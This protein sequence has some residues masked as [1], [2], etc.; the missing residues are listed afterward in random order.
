MGGLHR[1]L[2]VAPC[3]PC[4]FLRLP[5]WQAAEEPREESQLPP[6]ANVVGNARDIH[7]YHHDEAS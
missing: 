7:E 5:G 1:V 2:N 3:W 6:E 4:G